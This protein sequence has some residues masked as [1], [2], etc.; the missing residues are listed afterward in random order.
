MAWKGSARENRSLDGGGDNVR[1]S[2]GLNS[3]TSG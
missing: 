1:H 2:E 3:H